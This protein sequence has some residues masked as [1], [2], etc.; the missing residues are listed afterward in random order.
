MNIRQTY[1]DICYFVPTPMRILLCILIGTITLAIYLNVAYPPS[2]MSAE[3]IYN[4]CVGS[5]PGY[6][7]VYTRESMCDD[8]VTNLTNNGWRITNIETGTY[9]CHCIHMVP[10]K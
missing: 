5:G 2:P 1:N 4:R 9:S 7:D 8:V 6:I 10:D 3:R